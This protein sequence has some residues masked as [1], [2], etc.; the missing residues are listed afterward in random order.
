MQ[1]F[2]DFSNICVATDV[3]IYILNDIDIGTTFEWLEI[4]FQDIVFQEAKKVKSVVFL[5]L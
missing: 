1:K 2:K 3:H 5:H 4:D